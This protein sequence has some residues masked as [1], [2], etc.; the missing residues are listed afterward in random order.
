MDYKPRKDDKPGMD[1]QQE[2]DYKNLY[3]EALA[4]LEDA[5]RLISATIKQCKAQV[6]G[7]W[8][9]EWLQTH[10]IVTS[11]GKDL[12]DEGIR[13]YEEREE[14]GGHEVRAYRLD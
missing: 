5:Q 4:G 13:Q 8:Y 14:H 10:R 12:T 6:G 11:G 7:D 1:D 2:P 9:L 3:I